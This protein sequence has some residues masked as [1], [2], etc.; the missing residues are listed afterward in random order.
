[1][2]KFEFSLHKMLDYKD[3][4]LEKEKNALM[5]LHAQRQA[6]EE[7]IVRYEEQFEETAEEQRCET[8]QGTT[9]HQIRM[10]AFQMENIRCQLKQLR[11]DEKVLNAAIE[12][13]RRVVV[14]L[15]QEVSGLDKL[16]EK[17]REEYDY[18][19]RKSEELQISEMISEKYV[20]QQATVHS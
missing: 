3:S 1:M 2:K 14:S 7:K 4:M 11:N 13:Q 5:Q 8:M 6:L 18:S 19:I 17:Q 20:R 12:K 10:Y 16:K 9:A 15:S